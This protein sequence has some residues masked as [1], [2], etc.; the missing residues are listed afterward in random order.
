VNTVS[1]DAK[2]KCVYSN[3]RPNYRGCVVDDSE[4]F[5]AELLEQAIG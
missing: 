3:I 5:D 2:L 1:G 4:A